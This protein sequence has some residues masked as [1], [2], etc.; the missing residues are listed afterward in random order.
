M[1]RRL[2]HKLAILKS[3][4]D[5]NCRYKSLG[6]LRERDTYRRPLCEEMTIAE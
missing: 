2:L 5:V 4:L 3:R 1:A 6:D